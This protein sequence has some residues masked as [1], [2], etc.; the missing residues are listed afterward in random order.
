[1][2]LRCLW[3]VRGLR[4]S[5]SA[6]WVLVSPSATSPNTSTSRDVSPAGNSGTEDSDECLVVE[7]EVVAE[8]SSFERAYSMATSMDIARPCAS[9]SSHEASPNS[10]QAVV[11]YG[12]RH[13]SSWGLCWNATA[14]R[15]TSRSASAVPKSLAALRASP[16]P[17]EMQ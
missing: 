7:E 6:T 17:A 15:P 13:P 10:E 12:S 14:S 11:R 16:A 3:T 1:M 9:A 2:E 5:L 8:G 4:K